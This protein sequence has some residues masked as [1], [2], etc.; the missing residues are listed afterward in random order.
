VLKS[1]QAS[2]GFRDRLIEAHG[3]IAQRQPAQTVG[4]PGHG[5]FLLGIGACLFGVGA[6]L[7]DGDLAKYFNGRSHVADFVAAIGAWHDAVMV[8]GGEAAHALAKHAQ[9]YGDAF[10][11]HIQAHREARNYA[12]SAEHDELPDGCTCC[13]IGCVP[14]CAIAGQQIIVERDDARVQRG[15]SGIHCHQRDPGL[16]MIVL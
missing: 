12:R 9:W 7:G 6:I 8:A 3:E 5:D 10:A 2:V 4:H 14:L 1:S 13:C 15:H 16:I 11:D